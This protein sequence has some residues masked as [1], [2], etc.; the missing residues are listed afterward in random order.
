M[1]NINAMNCNSCLNFIGDY[2]IKSIEVKTGDELN[3]DQI[4]VILIENEEYE[5][6]VSMKE[7][8]KEGIGLIVR[9]NGTLFMQRCLKPVHA[10][11]NARR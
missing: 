11:R 3:G 8:K 6:R 2:E 7:G 4:I 5:L 9:E 1:S 10:C